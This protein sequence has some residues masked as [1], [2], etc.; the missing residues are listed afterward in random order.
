MLTC[1]S[2]VSLSKLLGTGKFPSANNRLF[3]EEC[4]I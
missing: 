3:G 1:G 4:F 2:D